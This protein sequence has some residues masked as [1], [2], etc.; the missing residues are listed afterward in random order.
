MKTKSSSGIPSES[1]LAR[2]TSR[3]RHLGLRAIPGIAI[4]RLL[5]LLFHFRATRCVWVNLENWQPVPCKKIPFEIRVLSAEEIKGQAEQIGE[6]P[7][8]LKQAVGD[9]A[10]VVAA[11]KGASIV[12]FLWIS[13]SPPALNGDYALEFD[14]RLAF[15]Y[16]AFTFPEFR[17]IGLMPAV[18]QAALEQCAARGHRGAIAC[19]SRGWIQRNCNIPL[20][21]NIWEEFGYIP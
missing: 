21:Q 16:R 8:G 6:N 17:G 5:S 15:C 1:P 4:Y 18:L 13:S 14:E 12:S 9:G 7:E 19:I 3:I 2:G 10:E 20:R 11:L